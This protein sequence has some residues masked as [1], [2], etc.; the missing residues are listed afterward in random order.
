MVGTVTPWRLVPALLRF[1]QSRD[2]YPVIVTAFETL[3][4]DRPYKSIC[5]AFDSLPSQKRRPISAK[6]A[7]WAVESRRGLP[8]KSV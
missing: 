5:P 1:V 2:A 6:R 7:T 4:F 8:R 3:S